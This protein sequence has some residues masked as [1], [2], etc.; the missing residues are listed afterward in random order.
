VIECLRLAK[1]LWPKS[2]WNDAIESLWMEELGREDPTMAIQCLKNVRVKR[3]GARVELAWVVGEMAAYKSNQRKSRP[4]EGE[5]EDAVERMVRE[6]DEAKADAK[7][8]LADLNLLDQD[9][10]EEL[11]AH[12]RTFLPGLRMSGHP[13]LWSQTAIG[14]AH[15]AGIKRALWWTANPEPSLESVPSFATD[16]SP[17]TD[18]PKQPSSGP[19]LEPPRGRQSTAQ[20]SRSTDLSEFW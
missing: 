14:L 19:P 11:A 15:A 10:I 17:S 13:S 5:A 3:P 16:E 4:V 18:Q 1:Q 9:T 12:V 6:R 20:D 7:V 2:D 8:M